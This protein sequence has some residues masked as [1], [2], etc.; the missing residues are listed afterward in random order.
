MADPIHLAVYGTLRRG[1]ANHHIVSRLRGKWH[2]GTV[3]GWVYEIAWGDAEGYPG[4]TLS[5]DAAPTP[6]DVLAAD[7]L[8]RHI[9]EVDRFEGP[10]YRRVVTT[11]KLE[12]GTEVAAWIYEAITDED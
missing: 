11:A 2:E 7:D 12:D 10:G 8:D 1:E 4:I 5:D 3:R 9:L 6:V